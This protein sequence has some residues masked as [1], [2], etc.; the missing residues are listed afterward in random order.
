MS[1]THACG[2]THAHLALSTADPTGTDDVRDRFARDLAARYRRLR[3][4]TRRLVGYEEDVFELRQAQAARLASPEDITRANSNAAKQQAFL[5]WLRERLREGVLEPT[6]LG[7]VQRGDHWT[8]EYIREA[9]VRGW[10]DARARLRNA[11]AEVGSPVDDVFN[12]PLPARQIRRIYTRQYGNLGD[13]TETTADK[14]RD[15]FAEGLVAGAN[16]KTMARVLTNELQDIQRRHAET[17]ARTA[18][19]DSYTVATLDRF[20]SEG[21]DDVVGASEVATADDARVCP[22]CESID[23]VE[24]AVSEARNGTFT[25]EPSESEPDHL[26]GQYPMRPPYHFRCRCTLLPVIA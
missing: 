1:T 24:F 12:A 9:Y 13:I 26:A 22:V 18:T 16:P 6:G 15:I 3:G 7:A 25:F 21:V 23:G 8:A 17:W 19:I 20:E 10:D 4:R 2:D 14:I 5:N 11:G